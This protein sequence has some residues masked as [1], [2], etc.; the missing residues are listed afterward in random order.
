MKKKYQN[1]A[2]L[3]LKKE[4][5][6]QYKDEECCTVLKLSKII[7]PWIFQNIF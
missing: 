6:S 7:F 1:E 4:K 2:I 5:K 3:C